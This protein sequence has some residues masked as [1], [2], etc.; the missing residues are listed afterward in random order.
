MGQSLVWVHGDGDT[1]LFA[2]LTTEV[3]LTLW[4]EA[5]VKKITKQK[6][7]DTSF[8]TSGQ[9]QR[10]KCGGEEFEMKKETEKCLWEE[11]HRKQMIYL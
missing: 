6:G 2:I 11:K 3:G 4:P 8:S 9:R 1:V 10:E 7:K 5:S